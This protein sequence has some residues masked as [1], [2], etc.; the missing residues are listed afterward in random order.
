[1]RLEAADLRALAGQYGT[2][3]Y[4]YS[5]AAVEERW[6]AFDDAFG[7]RPRLICYA[8]KAAS[9]IALL[10]L[11]A[12]LGS[13]FDIVSGGELA[14]VLKAGGDAARTVFS[15]VGKR[16]DEIEYALESGVRCINIESVGELRQVEACARAQNKSAAVALRLNPDIDAPTHTHTATG[17]AESKF[18]LS[19]ADLD[20]CVAYAG[21]SDALTLSGLSV[22]VG[23]QI[24]TLA[25]LMNGAKRVM[26]KADA[27]AQNG[28]A[29]RSLDFGGGLGVAYDDAPA[30]EPA[31]YV[32]A[33]LD[34]LGARDYLPVIEPGRSVVAGAGVLLTEALYIKDAGGKKIA[35]VD[36]GMNDFMRPAFYDARH[37]IMTTR[38]PGEAPE[39]YDIAGP[40][41]ESADFFARDRRLTLAQGDILAIRDAGAYGFSMASA[42]N[43]RPRPAEVL[44]DGGRAR[45][46][47]ERET[48]DA[49]FADE[50][51]LK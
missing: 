5:R 9:N 1:M 10:G 24:T 49:L 43:S 6:R 23:S 36:A 19:A 44:V 8:V 14:R 18:G 42:Y 32:G 13:G 7:E 28:V 34:A 33:L 31:E 25:P 27:L 30:P 38:P 12:R 46:I 22:H 20:E 35:V 40:V 47:R 11:L 50:R 17:H 45:L 29:I 51:P 41:C 4:V 3:L 15:G 48:R 39:T 26:E 37:E 2:P 16:R 21:A